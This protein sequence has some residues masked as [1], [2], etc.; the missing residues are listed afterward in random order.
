MNPGRVP[1]AAGSTL[2]LEM[3]IGNCARSDDVSHSALAP[4]TWVTT[5]VMG[6]PL[7]SL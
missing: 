1:F 6:S 7:Q 4:V 2:E 3:A 5:G